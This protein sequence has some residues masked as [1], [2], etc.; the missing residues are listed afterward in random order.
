MDTAAGAPPRRRR[1]VQGDLTERGHRGRAPGGTGRAVHRRP[2]MD[3]RGDAQRPRPPG[4]SCRPG[5]D[6]ADERWALDSRQ[7]TCSALL[8]AEVVELEEST[9]RPRWPSWCARG[10]RSIPATAEA[11]VAEAGGNPLLLEE[12]ATRGRPTSSLARALAGRLARLGPPPAGRWSCSPW[13]V[14]ASPRAS[15]GAERNEL[16]AAGVAVRG[17]WR[18]SS[19]T[20]PLGRG[21]HGR[22][23]RRSAVDGATSCSRACHRAWGARSSSRR[24]RAPSRSR[25]SRAGGRRPGHDADG[26][27]D[28]SRAGR[29]DDRRPGRGSRSIVAARL[30]VEH[31]WQ[32]L[33]AGDRPAGRDRV[34]RRRAHGRARRPHGPCMLGHRRPCRQRSGARARP[35]AR[36][37]GDL[38]GPRSP[39]RRR[40]DIGHNLDGDTARALRILD[41]AEAAGRRT[42]RSTSLRATIRAYAEG[43]DTLDEL[44][45]AYRSA[46][47]DPDAG[48]H[49]L[50]GMA[51]NVCSVALTMRGFEA[52]HASIAEAA[53]LLESRGMPGRADE[54]RAQDVQVLCLRRS[55]RRC[56]SAWPMSCSNAHSLDV[57]GNGPRR[58]GRLQ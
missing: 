48:S 6:D 58:C 22:N 49:A 35:R 57:P 37:R 56:R 45:R 19:P 23:V 55:T 50:I 8:G 47:A 41:R 33:R 40:G 11:M 42:P 53:E 52:A 25:S 43:I 3:R 7:L 2:P 38:A 44:R 5:D 13:L 18:D 15:S 4:G 12:L 34:G 36:G 30:L 29:A 39:G 28:P 31:R 10:R 32:R 54:L 21:G 24:R 1:S 9:A 16:V 20:C 51:T 27:R 46:A 17:R 14:T 26:T